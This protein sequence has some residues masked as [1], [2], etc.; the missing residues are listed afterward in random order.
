MSAQG[1][2]VLL[3][4]PSSAG[5]TSTSRALLSLL[6][7]DVVHFDPDSFD[8]SPNP[9]PASVPTLFNPAQAHFHWSALTEVRSGRSVVIEFCL[10][11]FEPSQIAEFLLMFRDVRVYL[12]SF[13]CPPSELE[14]REQERGDRRPGLARRQFE[15]LRQS[16][17]KLEYDLVLDSAEADACGRAKAI[18]EFIARHPQPQAFGNSLRRLP[19]LQPDEEINTETKLCGSP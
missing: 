10:A 5:K 14:R 19:P 1:T 13:C 17:V 12:V 8:F 18:A 3:H 11:L 6:E 4:G 15:E 2:M 9:A 16:G 7:G